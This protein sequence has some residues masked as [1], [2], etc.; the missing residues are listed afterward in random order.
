VIGASIGLNLALMGCAADEAC[1]TAVALSPGENYFG[2]QPADSV[3]AG[4]NAFLVAAHS[5]LESV[6]AVENFF[7]L[8][9]G[10]LSARLYRGRAHG[11]NLFTEHLE[12]L[13]SAIVSWLDEQFA[14]VEA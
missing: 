7:A 3:E 4:L 8:G 13:A 6:T 9:R 5:D 11:T 10:E 12:G 1:V 14:A 2:I